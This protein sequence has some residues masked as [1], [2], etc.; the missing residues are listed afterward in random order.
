M[1]RRELTQTSIGKHLYVPLYRSSLSSARKRGVLLV[2]LVNEQLHVHPTNGTTRP[3]PSGSSYDPRI[4]VFW[5][6]NP[7][8]GSAYT[9]GG[10]LVGARPQHSRRPRLLSS[11]KGPVWKRT[12]NVSRVAIGS[13]RI[14]CTHVCGERSDIERNTRKRKRTCFPLDRRRSRFHR[15]ISSTADLVNRF[16]Q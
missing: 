6:T 9:V 12:L 5:H 1:S 7:G 14:K 2:S 13:D 10:S 4:A 3:P 16:V 15:L 8:V 11:N